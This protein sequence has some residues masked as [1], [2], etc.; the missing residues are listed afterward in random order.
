MFDLLGF[1]D[2]ILNIILLL[3][4]PLVIAVIITMFRSGSKEIEELRKRY[5][6]Q[7]KTMN[8]Q[9]HT[10]REMLEL[11]ERQHRDE[12]KRYLKRSKMIVELNNAINAGA[13]KV[14]CPIHNEDVEI[15]ADGTII[16]RKGHRI[17]PAKVEFK[18]PEVEVEFPDEDED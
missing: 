17:W 12:L 7:I 5:E 2:L 18:E 6:T 1:R 16:C 13:V 10:L 14:I 11:K 15:L 3:I 8:D 4:I 9:I